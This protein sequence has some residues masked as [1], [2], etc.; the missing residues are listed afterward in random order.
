MS[1]EFQQSLGIHSLD[2]K[3]DD[4]GVT[5]NGGPFQYAVAWDRITGACLMPPK[6][7]GDLEE[8]QDLERAS[9]FLGGPEN[10]AKLQA[11]EQTM[12]QVSIAYRDK[13]NHLRKIEVPIPI[14]DPAFL[15]ELQSRLGKRWLGEAADEHEAEKKLH[16]APGIFKTIFIPAVLF[17]AVAVVLVLALIGML[18]PFLNLISIQ[19]MLLDLQDGDYGRLGSRVLLYAV[20][21]VMAFFLRRTWNSRLLAMKARFRGTRLPR[22]L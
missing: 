21:F 11:L 15:R 13:N 5:M 20:L 18:G 17:G 2:V 7:M 4:T 9:I 6:H 14:T 16:T 10:I 22:G 19:Q 12:R 3:V 8:K 1:P